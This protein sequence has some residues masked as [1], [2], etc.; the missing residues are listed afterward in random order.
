M[1]CET[2]T[3]A[4]PAWPPAIRTPGGSRGERAGLPAPSYTESH[5]RCNISLG[6]RTP[7]PW[8]A[9]EATPIYRP[10]HPERTGFYRILEGHF[11]TYIVAASTCWRFRARHA[12]SVPVVRPNAR[13]CSARSW[14]GR[15]PVLLSIATWSSPSPHIHALVTRGAFKRDGEFVGV[16]SVNTDVIEELFRRLVLTRLTRAERLSEEFRDNLL[17][18]VHSGFSVHAGPRIH[19]TDPEYLA[20]LGRYIVRVPMP[21]KDVRLTSE[22]QVRV[23]TPPDP[24]TGKTAL[25]LD[26]LDWIHAVTQQI[27][28]PRQHMARYYGAYSNRKRR[29]CRV[30]GKRRKTRR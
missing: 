13:R 10:R 19:P 12:T 27:P 14:P 4:H 29:R 20:R 11:E 25:V 5:G 28:A 2:E 7:A 16:G 17:S 18:W 21:S 3:T 1:G 9:R 8:A 15:S 23:A 30:R 26:P 6:P 24:R 22:G